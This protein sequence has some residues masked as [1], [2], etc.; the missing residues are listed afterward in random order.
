VRQ[1]S[2]CSAFFLCIKVGLETT[3]PKQKHSHKIPAN[4]KA[5]YDKIT[6]QTDPYCDQKLD[7]EY[8]EL[9]RYAVA[10]LARK[11][12]SPLL[13]GQTHSW[14]CAVIHAVGTAN[15][16]FDKSF[17]PYVGAAELA[18]D[19]HLSKS[20]VG[21]KSRQI[22]GLLKIAQLDHHWM[23]PSRKKASPTAWMILVNGFIVDARTL[24]LEIQQEAYERGMIPDPVQS[25]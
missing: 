12:P 22:R 9:I 3:I 20:T 6:R 13:K 19:F 2:G 21:N 17:T 18:Q 11:R 24:P 8:R 14:A 1:T 4:L 15:F 10:A 16:L 7:Q 23:L 25:V 5:L